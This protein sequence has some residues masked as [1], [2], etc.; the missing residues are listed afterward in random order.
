MLSAPR[1]RCVLQKYPTGPQL[2]GHFLLVNGT[3]NKFSLTVQLLQDHKV[4][5]FLLISFVLVSLLEH[6]SFRFKKEIFT[7]WFYIG[8][9]N[10]DY[11]PFP[12]KNSHCAHYSPRN[13]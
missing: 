1:D 5:I 2:T 13:V 9:A 6:L 11:I 12:H 4:S 10:S 7:S 8:R 3:K